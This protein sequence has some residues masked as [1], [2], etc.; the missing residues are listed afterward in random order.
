MKIK[1]GDRSPFTHI[2]NLKKKD[3]FYLKS[4][5]GNSIVVL[6]KN[7]YFERMEKLIET[8]PY[9]ELKKDPLNKMIRET[10]NIIN[11]SKIVVEEKSRFFVK[12]Q[13]PQIPKLYGLPKIH[14]PGNSMRPIVSNINAPTYNLAKHLVKIFSLFKKHDSLSVKNNIELVTKLSDVKMENNDRLISFDVVALFPSIPIETTLIF[15]KN[16]LE[17]LKIEG[18]KIKELINLTKLCMRQNVFQFNGKYYEQING[19]AMGNPLSP[20][21]ADIFMS[22][23]ET[24]LR[25]QSNFPKIWLRYVDDIFAIIDKD[26]NLDTFLQQINSQYT[27]I[28]FTYE[29]ET[30]GKLPFLDLLIKRIDNNLKF[31]IYRK[32]TH[33]YRYIQMNS[34]HSWQHKMAAWNSMIYRLINIPMDQ[35]AFDKELNLIKEIAIFNGYKKDMIL[36]LVK[37]HKW[38]KQINELSSLKSEIDTVKKRS[39]L[40]FIPKLSN[41]ITKVF[42][43]Y[44]VEIVSSK[45]NNFK[46]LIGSTKDQLKE[47]QKSGIYSIQCMDCDKCYVG[48]TRRNIGIRFKEHLRNIKNQEDEKSPLAEHVLGTN[49][50]I[51]SI[52]LLKQVN[53]SQ[54]LNVREAIEMTKNK[55][56]LLNWDLNPL[57]NSL[58]K[59]LK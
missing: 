51:N 8:G 39:A 46:S 30:D 19:T 23:F 12:V 29:K 5:K 35:D 9:K 15:L 44:N 31:E 33:T 13:N 41:Q 24:D 50:N 56:N 34:N 20:F 10:N 45:N 57:Q 49:H 25:K 11:S 32:K 22:K 55:N 1:I 21:L 3:C 58:L 43:K 36:R 28:K 16:W 6:K 54:E 38:K 59:L 18:E 2:K 26:F 7:D 53:N 40:I 17:E 42:K 52:K 14:K 48:Q 47:N 37:K 27:S 4:D